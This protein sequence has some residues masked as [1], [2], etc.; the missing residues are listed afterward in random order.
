MCEYFETVEGY[1]RTTLWKLYQTAPPIACF[2]IQVVNESSNTI[3]DSLEFSK[4]R[5]ANPEETKC[6]EMRLRN[7][8]GRVGRHSAGF[9]RI[10][11]E[12]RYGFGCE[13]AVKVYVPNWV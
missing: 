8:I 5:E 12:F 2:S 7:L 9:P 1:C 6:G 11:C 4:N 3:L 13:Y 10:L